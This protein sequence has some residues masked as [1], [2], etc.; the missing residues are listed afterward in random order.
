[1]KSSE[2]I[3][4]QLKTLTSLFPY[5]K[6]RYK[7]EPLSLC[8][9]IEVLPPDEYGGNSEYINFERQFENNFNSFYVDEDIC[10]LTGGSLF[11]IEDADFEMKGVCYGKLSNSSIHD[12]FAE[13]KVNFP[14]SLTFDKFQK[15]VS[16]NQMNF[17]T[18][19]KVK[20]DENQNTYS[21][22]LEYLQAA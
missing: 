22:T 2:H 6:V 16:F 21:V 3:I 8:H 20:V 19:D 17:I 12:F 13:Y 10:F 15:N 9:F 14:I 4:S 11:E 1:M 5:L 18:G 7:F